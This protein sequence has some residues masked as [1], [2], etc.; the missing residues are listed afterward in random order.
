MTSSSAVAVL[1]GLGFLGFVSSGCS[2]TNMRFIASEA[3]NHNSN[4]NHSE[5]APTPS[6]PGDTI[7]DI[8][9]DDGN[10]QI[11]P[12]PSTPSN[13]PIETQPEQPVV[14]IPPS[15][16]PEP[17]QPI[18][19]R[20]PPVVDNNLYRTVETSIDVQSSGKID[21]L[22]ITD[23]SGSM[24]YKQKSMA[25][26]A[27][28][29]LSIL[30]GV[31]WQIG[32]TT[33]DV[34]DYYLGDGKLV[35]LTG[36]KGSYLLTSK[37]DE[38]KASTLLGNTLHRPK[39][40]GTPWEQGIYASYRAVERAL[41][42]KDRN[43]DLI[44]PDA[45]LAVVL[46]SDEDETK[47]HKEKNVPENFINLVR[48]GYK[49]KKAVTFHS[50][51]VKPGDSVCLKSEKDHAYGYAYEKLSRL[52]GGLVGS[53]CATDYAA[54]VEGIAKGIKE[55]LK[56]V[57]LACSPIVNAQKTVKV[58]V[59]GALYTDNFKIQGMNIIFDHALPHG[60]VKFNYSCLK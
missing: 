32:I 2:G 3:A 13:P 4:L 11:N 16:I 14:D 47:K 38:Q 23:N 34:Y 17:Q 26:R 35:D 52:T 1:V 45:Q 43:K 49:G 29:F 7:D 50:I 30:R 33:T 18:P 58:T 40:L 53:V 20:E 41:E 21:I 6:I 56:A 24:E 48:S 12:I 57:T 8:V 25:Y 55:S 9:E 27:R 15:I 59:D 42:G 28:N 46:I 39:E 31:D 51:I 54:Q 60:K 36:Q 22:F 5:V 10:I 19:P 37:M 44:R